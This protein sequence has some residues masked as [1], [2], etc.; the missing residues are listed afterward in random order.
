MLPCSSILST[1]NERKK[2]PALSISLLYKILSEKIKS[3]NNIINPIIITPKAIGVK[4]LDFSISIL[5]FFGFRVSTFW[6]LFF[7]ANYYILFPFI[8]INNAITAAISSAM[9]FQTL[10]AT[11]IPGTIGPKNGVSTV[12]STSSRA[13]SPPGEKKA[14]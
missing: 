13:P 10:A 14:R 1:K 3:I 2:N 11:A 4:Y 12:I 7:F 9:R 5:D 6:F 8:F